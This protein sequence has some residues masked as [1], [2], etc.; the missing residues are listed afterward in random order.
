MP[1]LGLATLSELPSYAVE[2]PT[3]QAQVLSSQPGLATAA[4]TLA[5][6]TAVPDFQTVELGPVAAPVEP[7]EVAPGA[8]P[9]IQVT[10]PAGPVIVDLTWPA[11]LPKA[12]EAKSPQTSPKQQSRNRLQTTF[13][14]TRDRLSTQDFK[15]SDFFGTV[16]MDRV[17]LVQQVKEGPVNMINELLGNTGP[18]KT[19]CKNC[20][21]QA[22]GG[23]KSLSI[24]QLR[25]FRQLL[26]AQLGLQESAFGDLEDSFIYFDF[27]GNG[28]LDPRE[29]YMLV[30]FHLREY[31]KKLGG[32][33]QAHVPFSS[34]EGMGYRVVR[35]LGEGGQGRA[36][37][38]VHKS[39]DEVCIKSYPKSKANA[40]GVDD[41]KDELETM[42]YLKACPNIAD[43]HEIF[44]DSKFYYL[45]GDPYHGG[46]LV[47]FKQRARQQNVN[48]S[49]DWW[50]D[51]ALQCF[52]GLEFMH[53]TA[54][55]HCD[56]K[57]PNIML[58]HPDFRTPH[59]V[60][61]DLG[62]ATVMAQEG[63]GFPVG[64]PGYIPPETWS[65]NKWYPRGDIFS[66]AVTLLQLAIDRVPDPERHVCGIFQEVAMVP[67]AAA[68]MQMVAHA[69]HTVVPPVHLVPAQMPGFRKLLALCLEKD[70]NVR[71]R[72]PQAL[73]DNWFSGNPTPDFDDENAD[74]LGRPRGATLVSP[75]VLQP[76][77][78]SGP[79]PQVGA[80]RRDASATPLPPQARVQGVA[81]PQAHAGCL[82]RAL[83][84]GQPVHILNPQA[85]HAGVLR[86]DGTPQRRQVHMQ[87][88]PQM[89]PSPGLGLNS[90][91]APPP[92]QMFPPRQLGKMPSASALKVHL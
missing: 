42:A 57:E 32:H 67:N 7:A 10:P 48:M 50:R 33:P 40:A 5:A 8:G 43:C 56:I 65:T 84:P 85:A 83:S 13:E 63:R 77:P 24:T 49:E 21:G 31:R 6:Q 51:I 59:I 35:L 20:M 41:L 62:L 60:L 58:K 89:Q 86:R 17:G 47:K 15:P 36:E 75:M 28:S 19:L 3:V 38:G 44:Q 29:V 14:E 18:L 25:V 4:P 1:S 87:L 69:T 16:K 78:T 91:H 76:R 53:G 30:K 52:Q 90:P 64:T 70:R 27:D 2:F 55:M 79:P 9:V 82:R 81:T 66:M 23:K 39:G 88:S 68:M 37:L 80:L 71:P 92:R 12:A 73:A 45:I 34:L 61:I 22:G 72:A 46:D 11:D 26:A 54:L 74:A